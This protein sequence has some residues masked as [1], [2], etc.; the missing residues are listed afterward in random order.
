MMIGIESHH[1]VWTYHI[2]I[3]TIRSLILHGYHIGCRIDVGASQVNEEQNISGAQPHR[4]THS[5]V[6]AVVHLFHNGCSY[7]FADD[8]YHVTQ[9]R[10]ESKHPGSAESANQIT[11]L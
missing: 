1:H 8:D 9:T 10:L 6:I 11:F 4:H 3:H 2:R 7:L 5:C